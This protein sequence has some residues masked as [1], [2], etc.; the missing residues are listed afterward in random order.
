MGKKELKNIDCLFCKIIKKEVPA[1]IVYEDQ[2][3]VAFNDI[4]PKAPLHILI[5]PKK[6]IC[7]VDYLEDQEKELIG[8][9]FLTAKKIAKEQGVSS[10]EGKGYRLVFNV[11]KEG[12]QIIEHLHLHLLGKW[13]NNK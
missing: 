6:H 8:E 9:L 10:K 2:N 13:N 12:G 4:N 5:V 3:F 7:S 1:D 11:G